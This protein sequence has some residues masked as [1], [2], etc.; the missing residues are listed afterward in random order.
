MPPP[1]LAAA[2]TLVSPAAFDGLTQ[3]TPLGAH[4]RRDILVTDSVLGDLRRVGLETPRELSGFLVAIDLERRTT[5]VLVKL[6]LPLLLMTIVMHTTPHFPVALTK[7]KVTVAITA[8]L[9]GAVFLSAINSQLGGVGYTI[10]IAYVFYVFFALGLLCV[11]YV[12]GFE[13]LR[14]GGRATAA[15]R[16]EHVMRLGFLLAVAATAVGTLLLYRTGDA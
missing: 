8:A 1:R 5:A 6:L 16:L 13:A 9:S 7:E 12:T 14:L 15:S 4:E 2:G 3:W 11:V 10:A